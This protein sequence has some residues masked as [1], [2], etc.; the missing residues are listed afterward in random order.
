MSTIFCCCFFNFENWHMCVENVVFRVQMWDVSEFRWGCQCSVIKYQVISDLWL[1]S[2]YTNKNVS[3]EFFIHVQRA[4]SW[5]MALAPVFSCRSLMIGCR[6]YCSSLIYFWRARNLSTYI[7]SIFHII[8]LFID[9]AL[10]TS[11]FLAASGPGL[12]TPW[13]LCLKWWPTLF[14][15][16]SPIAPARSGTP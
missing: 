1:V 6:F 11:Y 7:W 13:C 16:P 4:E 3:F 14:G 15:S 12:S 5:F 2:K 10:S 9:V 8:T